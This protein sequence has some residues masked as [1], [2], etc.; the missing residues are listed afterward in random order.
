MAILF[1]CCSS[2]FAVTTASTNKDTVTD[3]GIISLS[4]PTNRL[5]GL[6]SLSR[7]ETLAR[8]NQS[9]H[10][11]PPNERNVDG[12]LI[13]TNSNG[14]EE[15]ELVIDTDTM[16]PDDPSVVASSTILSTVTIPMSAA[17]VRGSLESVLAKEGLATSNILLDKTSPQA[18]AFHH[19]VDSATGGTTTTTTTRATTTTPLDDMQDTLLECYVLL[20]FYYATGGPDWD[21]DWNI[22]NNDVT[23]HHN[24]D[25]TIAP[26]CGWHGVECN[27]DGKVFVLNLADNGLVGTIPTRE[28]EALHSLGEFVFMDMWLVLLFFGLYLPCLGHGC[29]SLSLSFCV[30]LL[31]LFLDHH[32][33]VHPLLLP[34][35][36]IY[37]HN[38]SRL[39]VVARQ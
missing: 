27:S 31:T 23:F 30:L 33:H 25:D 11:D 10:F 38:Q 35:S 3:D 34:L 39:F 18:K 2:I 22:N 7:T 4:P 36:Y 17:N 8:I 6:Q 37:T 14:E 15:E 29:L 12:S 24:D 19:L 1:F 21:F 16:D 28:L 26:Y 13:E 32:D 5:R 9:K 20:V